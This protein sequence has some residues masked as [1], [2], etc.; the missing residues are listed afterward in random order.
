MKNVLDTTSMPFP[1]TPPANPTT[2]LDPDRLA[3][4]LHGDAEVGD[5]GV[6][7]V[8]VDRILIDGIHVLPEANISTQVEFKP[9][10]DRGHRPGPRPTSP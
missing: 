6:V 1:Q 9:V 8:S 3:A 5:E 10:S 2:P 7:T 4:I